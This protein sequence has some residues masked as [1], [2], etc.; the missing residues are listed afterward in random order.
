MLYRPLLDMFF[1]LEIIVLRLN[2]PMIVILY[3][4]EILEL[5][6]KINYIE[7]KYESKILEEILQVLLPKG[8]VSRQ[9]LP[10]FVM[11]LEG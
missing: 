9:V 11:T 2:M 6:E 10:V 1:R 7:C 4:P 8:T 3:M 5:V